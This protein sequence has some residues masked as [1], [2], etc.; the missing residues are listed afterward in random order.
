MSGPGMDPLVAAR[1]TGV[2]IGI[3][4][5]DKIIGQWL[6]PDGV[7]DPALPIILNISVSAINE[8]Q[9]DLDIE[10]DRFLLEWSLQHEQIQII[11]LE[12]TATGSGG[13]KVRLYNSAVG[14]LLL[15]KN[16]T[17]ILAVPLTLKPQI[18]G[19]SSVVARTALVQTIFNACV[20]KLSQLKVT[21][22]LTDISVRI[23]GIKVVLPK[24]I[25]VDGK[26]DTNC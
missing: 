19:A 1:K 16:S 13:A 2:S 5:L 4:D 11:P 7:Q 20:I 3:P 9:Y 22:S 18:I 24:T 12:S 6:S 26:A 23:F 8:N 21:Y 10:I 17:S 14:P 25:R 15:P